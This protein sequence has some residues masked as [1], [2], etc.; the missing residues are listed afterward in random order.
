MYICTLANVSFNRLDYGRAPGIRSKLE[1]N[2]HYSLSLSSFSFCS[3]PL[4]IC[5]LFVHRQFAFRDSGNSYLFASL[6]ILYNRESSWQSLVHMWDWELGSFNRTVW[7]TAGVCTIYDVG[8]GSLSLSSASLSLCEI[9]GLAGTILLPFPPPSPRL[10]SCHRQDFSNEKSKIEVAS[11]RFY[12]RRI[13]AYTSPMT[14]ERQSECTTGTRS[15][16]VETRANRVADVRKNKNR[17]PVAHSIKFLRRS[18]V[19]YNNHLGNV[20]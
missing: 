6:A 4:S 19:Q 18:N 17:S 20:H 7:K 10:P 11:L 13:R 16:S 14:I 9:S 12:R 1:D 3:S 2:S 5:K 8:N 15:E